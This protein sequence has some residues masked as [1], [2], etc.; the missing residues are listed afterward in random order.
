MIAIDEIMEKTGLTYNQIYGRL[1]R[2][3]I[4]PVKIIDGKNYYSDSVFDF[5]KGKKRNEEQR[6]NIDNDSNGNDFCDFFGKE[7][8]KDY[9]RV[10]ERQL[11]EKD[12]QLKAKDE[13]IKNLQ[14]LLSQ[15]QQLHLSE[16][17]RL[18]LKS[19]ENLKSNTGYP[20][21]NKVFEKQNIDKNEKKNEKKV[22]K[23]NGYKRLD[24][25]VFANFL[26]KI[27]RKNNG[28]F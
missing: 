23:N 11:E 7:L 19:D 20:E 10:F 18:D 12:R 21:E 5:L 6:H 27:R 4:K 15:E 17:R 26:R 1:V 2:R 3:N 16:L 14:L 25:N 13:Q 22:E 9:F 28:N 8:S 24:N